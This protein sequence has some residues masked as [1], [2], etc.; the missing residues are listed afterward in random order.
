MNLSRLKTY[1]DA[2]DE[3]KK[4][5]TVVI[6]KGNWHYYIYPGVDDAQYIGMKHVK[7]GDAITG[8]YVVEKK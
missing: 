5:R 1:F 3:F 6:E 4:G 2:M 8:Y 7:W